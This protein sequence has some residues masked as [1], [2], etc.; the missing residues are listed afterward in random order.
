[1]ATSTAMIAT[2]ISSS[3]RVKPLFPRDAQVFF[4]MI[5]SYRPC[6]PVLPLLFHQVS[7]CHGIPCG[8]DLKPAATCLSAVPA[9]LLL[10]FAFAAPLA[11]RSLA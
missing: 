10:C 4:H 2:T 1:M 8:K 6:G 7:H 11:G 3:A 9:L 5:P